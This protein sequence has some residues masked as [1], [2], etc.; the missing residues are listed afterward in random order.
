MTEKPAPKFRRYSPEARAAMLVAAGLACL[1]RGGITAFTI[2]NICRE[3][4]ASRGLITHHF[5]S[6]NGLLA[7]VYAAAYAPFLA[8]LAPADG[9]EPDLGQLIAAAF[10]DA[11]F[12]RDN[13]NV[14]LALWGEVAVNP[15]LRAAHRRHYEA[16]HTSVRRAVQRQTLAQGLIVDA[17]SL[18]V[19][20]I[21][22]I[23]G[24]WLEQHIDPE[25]LSQDGARAACLQILEPV[26]GPIK[27][28]R[29]S[30]MA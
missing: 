4:K 28:S 15:T 11:L 16:Y 27:I 2:D 3:A 30:E 18:S 14:W 22:L 26:L 24:Y 9:H 5:G 19:S 7:A 10:S 1:A 23:D 13:L 17:E 12:A 6:K 21:A 29:R 8:A 25:R 20:I